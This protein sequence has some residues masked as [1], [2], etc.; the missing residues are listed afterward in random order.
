MRVGTVE[1]RLLAAL[2]EHVLQPAAV[3]YLVVGV[4]QQLDAVRAVQGEARSAVEAELARVETE[5]QNIE[6]AIVQG[7]VGKTT[8][9]LLQDREGRRDALHARLR[10][11]TDRPTVSPLRVGPAEIQACLEDLAALLKQDSTRANRVFRQVLEP[12]TMTP[13]DNGGRRF[14]RASG[15]AKGLKCST[16][17]GWPRRSISVVVGA[18]NHLPANRSL[19]FWFDVRT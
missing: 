8:A 10:A 9:A 17:W 2:Q 13:V 16:A 11:L 12:I 18:R 14:Y 4:N 3:E 7:V 19:E 15:A 5:L 1:T 6:G